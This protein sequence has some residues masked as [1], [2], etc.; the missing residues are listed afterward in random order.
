M[1]NGIYQVYSIRYSPTA[2]TNSY[3]FMGRFII[4]NGTLEHLEDHFGVLDRLMPEG[5]LR[6][7]EAVLRRLERSPY[8]KVQRELP[9]GSPDNDVNEPDSDIHPIV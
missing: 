9:A 5:P 4:N 8:W 7:Q 2:Q 3:R 6:T 1:E